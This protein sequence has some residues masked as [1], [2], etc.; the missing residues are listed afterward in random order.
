MRYVM[1]CKR[2]LS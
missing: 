2:A 1:N